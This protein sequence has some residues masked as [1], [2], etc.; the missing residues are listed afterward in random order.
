[1]ISFNVDCVIQECGLTGKKYTFAQAK[2]A[3]SYIGRS[4]LNIG[5]KKGD[6]VALVAPN[7]PD[8]ILGFLGIL[9]GGLICTTMNPQYTAGKLLCNIHL[10]H[11]KIFPINEIYARESLSM[12]VYSI[13]KAKPVVN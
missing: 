13:D 10:R 5:L 12:S 4:L 11:L 1:M 9:S 2:D 6:V 7:L 3:T 8:G